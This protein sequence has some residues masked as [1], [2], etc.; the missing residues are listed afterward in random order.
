MIVSKIGCEKDLKSMA[1]PFGEDILDINSNLQNGKLTNGNDVLG[2]NSC[3][4][5]HI[6]AINTSPYL[7]NFKIAHR[8]SGLITF[9][10]QLYQCPM[11]KKI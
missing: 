3:L 4:N 10:S 2:Q 1:Q 9:P 6:K 8:R 5:S 11:Q 7:K